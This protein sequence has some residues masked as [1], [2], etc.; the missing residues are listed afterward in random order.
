[1]Y[2]NHPLRRP[3]P[4]DQRLHVRRRTL[5]HQRSP[6]ANDVSPQRQHLGPRQHRPVTP[7]LPECWELPPVPH[8]R[9]R[10]SLSSLR[11]VVAAL[12]A[13]LLTLPL[14]SDTLTSV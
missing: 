13:F 8:A 5:D 7:P 12:L 10:R 4:D 9:T 11:Y 3:H 6:D 2:T 14:P 1:S